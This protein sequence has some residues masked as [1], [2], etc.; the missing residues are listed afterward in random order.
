MT[1]RHRLL[2]MEFAL[3]TFFRAL[4]TIYLA[5][6]FVIRGQSGAFWHGPRAMPIAASVL[7]YALLLV[8]LVRQVRQDTTPDQPGEILRP[9]L[10][11][12]PPVPTSFCSSPWVTAC[13]RSFSSRPCS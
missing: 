4:T 5:Q 3:P 6:A 9:L 12:L 2:T 7:M 13:R 8:V 11:T 1:G 10:V